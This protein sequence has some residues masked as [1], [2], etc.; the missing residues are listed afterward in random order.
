MGVGGL[1]RWAWVPWWEMGRVVVDLGDVKDGQLRRGRGA[2]D[3][4]V[5]QITPDASRP[6]AHPENFGSGSVS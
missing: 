6:I 3:G 4:D 1:G 5:L 2:G